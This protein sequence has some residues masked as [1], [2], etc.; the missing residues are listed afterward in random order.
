MITRAALAGSLDTFR[1]DRLR[2][3]RLVPGHLDEIRRMHQD[4]AVM[5]HLGGVRSEEAT[6]AYLERNL[7]HWQERGYGLWILCDLASNRVAGRAVLRDLELD[8]TAEIEL[9]YAFYPD[10]W[11]RG[12]AT[13]IARELAR[14]GLGVLR[15][16][17][18]VAITR[19]SNVG[20]QR[21]LENA[22]L[23]REREITHESEVHLLFRTRPDP[24]LG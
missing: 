24:R 14:L 20:S 21:V 2:A 22:G 6:V 18:V 8:G 23:V 10:W 12:L 11:R 9:G 13:E 7:R 15:R 17:S 4:A 19:P 5:A 16:R 3:E 1:T